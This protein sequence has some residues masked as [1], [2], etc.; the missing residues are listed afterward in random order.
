MPK[1]TWNRILEEVVRLQVQDQEDPPRPGQATRQDR[2]RRGKIA[3][4]EHVTKRPL[5]IYA[6]PCTS[7]AKPIPAEMLMLDFT[8]KIGFKTVT[9]N[10]DPPALDILS[11]LS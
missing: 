4:V 5:I 6:S 2:Y 3:A 10:I 7:P 11:C 1:S 8:D 9:E